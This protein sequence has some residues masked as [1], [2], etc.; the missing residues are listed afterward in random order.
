MPLERKG[1]PGSHS[2][3]K[4]SSCFLWPHPCAP[5]SVPAAQLPPFIPLVAASVLAFM[6]AGP[7]EP[8]WAPWAS[9]KAGSCSL[10][11]Y[12]TAHCRLKGSSVTAAAVTRG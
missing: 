10:K 6:S 7:M 2:G 5:H 12:L 1:K 8:L 9:S 11:T 4:G 3:N